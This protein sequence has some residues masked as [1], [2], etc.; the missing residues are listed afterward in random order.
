MRERLAT[1][2]PA[3]HKDLSLISIVPKW[4]GAEADTPV[5]DFLAS[6][7]GAAKTARWDGTDCLRIATLRLR[8]PA[9]AFYKSSHKLQAGDATWEGFKSAFRDRFKDAHTDQYHF[10]KLQTAKQGKAEGPQEFADRCKNLAEKI[11]LKVNDSAAQRIQTENVD[12][13]VLR[14]MYRDLVLM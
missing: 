11:M 14:A 13:I 1:A 6:I 12:R 7:E 3:L 2:L 9:K 5:E 8:D 10:L 4:S